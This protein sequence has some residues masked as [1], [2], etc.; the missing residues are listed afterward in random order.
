MKNVISLQLVVFCN[1]HIAPTPDKI[2]SIMERI[3]SLSELEFLPSTITAQN[4]DVF[5]R[6]VMNVSNLS[7]STLVAEKACKITYHDTRIDVVF[8]VT[9]NTFLNYEQDVSIASKLLETV[10]DV[11]NIVGNRLAF[12]VGTVNV[13]GSDSYSTLVNSMMKPLEFYKERTLDEWAYSCNIRETV[14]IKGVK[15]AVNVLTDMGCA[16]NLVTIEK[17]LRCQTDINTL[18]EHGEYRFSACDIQHFI[19]AVK[20][21]A[22]TIM[23]EFERIGLND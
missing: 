12:I 13:A 19:N 20:P 5:T 11:D 21:T 7:F 4:I 15:E 23:S 1:R 10:M 8:D 2:V 3:N 18:P 14:D 6:Q 16:Q 9:S 22:D 17:G